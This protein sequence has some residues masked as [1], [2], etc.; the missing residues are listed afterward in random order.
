[1]RLLYQSTPSFHL[2]FT[3]KVETAKY[4]ETMEEPE[5]MKW[6]N[7][8]SQGYRLRAECYE[9]KCRRTAGTQIST[10]RPRLKQVLPTHIVE[11][12]SYNMACSL[13]SYN[14]SITL[15]NF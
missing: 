6:L 9:N 2:T 14:F 11:L 15:N 5:H 8:K 4:T 1:V 7:P 12:L 10:R 3:L 13:I